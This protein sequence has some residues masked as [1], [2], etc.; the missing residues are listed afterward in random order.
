MRDIEMLLLMYEAKYKVREPLSR[1]FLRT[2]TELDP[3]NA[4]KF[5]YLE[6]HLNFIK[7][8][9]DLYRLQVAAHNVIDPDF[10]PPVASTLGYGD[11]AEAGKRLYRDFLSRTAE[12]AGVIT[13]LIK[14]IAI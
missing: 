11:S 7:N 5:V 1:K 13:G 4:E 2:L 12:A 10:L 14:K 3:E 8:L 6:H 9:R